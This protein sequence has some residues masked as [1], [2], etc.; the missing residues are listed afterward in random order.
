M[1][2]KYFIGFV[3]GFTIANIIDKITVNE[4]K[5]KEICNSEEEEGTP[6]NIN[7]NNYNHEDYMFIKEK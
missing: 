6:T 5:E 3:I 1:V 2:I 7:D 4:K